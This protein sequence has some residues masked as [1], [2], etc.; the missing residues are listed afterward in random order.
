MSL[1]LATA[2]F[3][4]A[5]RLL[6]FS[7]LYMIAAIIANS[8]VRFIC[9]SPQKTIFYSNHKIVRALLP[10]VHMECFLSVQRARIYPIAGLSD[11]RILF[12][13][14]IRPAERRTGP[15]TW[16]SWGPWMIITKLAKYL[17]IRCIV[18]T[19]RPSPHERI[20]S[21]GGVKPDGSPWAGGHRVD[22]IL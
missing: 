20:H 8:P 10:E 22:V 1:A 18:K 13:C 4:S 5:L 7:P 9:L 11:L 16:R 2:P 15:Q 17:R 12:S 21:V 14:L 3:T 19:D 6:A